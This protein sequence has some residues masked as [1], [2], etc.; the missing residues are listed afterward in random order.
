MTKKE[1]N[2]KDY[3]DERNLQHFSFI[4][5]NSILDVIANY[6]PRIELIRTIE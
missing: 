4:T 3:D 2:E 6:E 5:T 1:T